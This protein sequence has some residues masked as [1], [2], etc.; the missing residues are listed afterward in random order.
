MSPQFKTVSE[1]C[2]ADYL[3]EY[4]YDWEYEPQFPGKSKK[5][6]FRVRR[7]AIECLLDVKERSPKHAPPGARNFDPIKGV[8]KKIEEG[9]EKF[10]AFGDHLCGLVLY[11]NGDCDTRFNP[12][13]I[14]GA[15]LGDP[16]LTVPFDVKA[17]TLDVESAQSEFLP[18]GGK[19]IRHYTPLVPHE[20]TM[21]ISAVI[22]P[23]LYGVPNP[24][25]DR[26][27]Q[28]EID[29]RQDHL[30]RSLHADERAV[31]VWEVGPGVPPT[32]KRVPR[33]VVCTNPFARPFPDSIF[34]SPY[35]ERWAIHND[36]LERVFAGSQVV[37]VEADPFEA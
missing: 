9:R 23:S 2:F 31:V 10:K 6:D 19:M 14:F 17:G 1:Q 29:R 12:W 8:R 30:G 27:V 11:N 13:C 21:N 20:S 25:F 18:R 28:N 34:D 22:V 4:G 7:D 37:D 16:G 3:D 5:P 33:V 35:D 26:A 15:M 32:L 24:E 36:S